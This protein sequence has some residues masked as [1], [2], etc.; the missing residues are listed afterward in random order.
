MITVYKSLIPTG[1]EYSNLPSDTS[2][3]TDTLDSTEFTCTDCITA[4]GQKGKKG[5]VEPHSY[6]TTRTI[7]DY[8][9]GEI[10][11]ESLKCL[12]C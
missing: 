1:D 5:G 2:N 7:T 4:M 9:T 11:C 6:Q 12:L 10:I 8:E 3:S